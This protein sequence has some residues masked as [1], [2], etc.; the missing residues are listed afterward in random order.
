ML[1]GPS[2]T[3]GLGLSQCGGLSPPPPT[4]PTCWIHSRSVHGA[5]LLGRGAG[6]APVTVISV[7]CPKGH[8]GSTYCV[9]DSLCFPLS[10]PHH[11]NHDGVRIRLKPS[12]PKGRGSERVRNSLQKA[13]EQEGT[14]RPWTQPCPFP[15]G[16][17]RLVAGAVCPGTG[18]TGCAVCREFKTKD[19]NDGGSVALSYLSPSPPISR[20]E[21]VLVKSPSPRADSVRPSAMQPIASAPTHT[22]CVYGCAQWEGPRDP[23]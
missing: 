5:T 3:H 1:R 16:P 21:Q 13:K 4:L 17:R 12:E 14:P 18:K 7:L 6:A 9:L 22:C 10:F 8:F 2:H 23:S 15:L 19:D 20:S 11:N